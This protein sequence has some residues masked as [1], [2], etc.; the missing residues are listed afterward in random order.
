MSIVIAVKKQGKIVIGSDSKCSDINTLH[1]AQ[2]KINSSKIHFLKHGT[3]GHVGETTYHTILDYLCLEHEDCFNFADRMSTYKSMLK[4]QKILTEEC[5]SLPTGNHFKGSGM[6][7]LIATHKTIFHIDP[8]RNVDEFSRFWAIGSGHS[9]ALGS[10]ESLYETSL[11]AE[12]IV[13]QTLHTVCKYDLHSNEPYH[14][15]TID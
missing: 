13:E 1:P 4:I 10:L 9:F 14:T 15:H 3:I 2:E 7:L 8:E 12:Q 5:L 11:A 6:N